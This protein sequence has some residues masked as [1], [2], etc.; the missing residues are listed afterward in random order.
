MLQSSP[1]R[2][3]ISLICSIIIHLHN[4]LIVST[5]TVQQ[6]KHNRSLYNYICV[7]LHNCSISQC[8]SFGLLKTFNFVS[9]I[10]HLAPLRICKPKKSLLLSDYIKY[11]KQLSWEANFSRQ[12]LAFMPRSS[13]YSTVFLQNFFF[14]FCFIGCPRK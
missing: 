14:S 11:S 9:I 12:F 5:N 7:V 3:W 1:M 8:F 13:I 4:E 6:K 10:F 2:S